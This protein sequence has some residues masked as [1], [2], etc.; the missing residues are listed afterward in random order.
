M[1]PPF[2][3]HCLA[4]ELEPGSELVGLFQQRLEFVGSHPFVVADFVGVDVEIHVGANEENVVD[5]SDLH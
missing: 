5:W 4:D 2:K 1:A 3:Q